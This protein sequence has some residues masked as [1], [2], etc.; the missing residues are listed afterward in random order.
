MGKQS[1]RQRQRGPN[2]AAEI[3]RCRDAGLP[4]FTGQAEDQEDEALARKLQSEWQE[5]NQNYRWKRLR[6]RIRRMSGPGGRTLCLKRDPELTRSRKCTVVELQEMLAV[7]ERHKVES[8]NGE[9]LMWNARYDV[10]TDWFDGQAMDEYLSAVVGFQ[11]AKMVA[12]GSWGACPVPLTI[13]KRKFLLMDVSTVERWPRIRPHWPRFR[14]RLCGLCPNH[15]HLV[16]P[17]YL[18]CSGCGVARYCSGACQAADWPE[19]Q[20]C[21]ATLRKSAEAHRDARKTAR[22][23]AEANRASAEANRASAEA[24]HLARETACVAASFVTK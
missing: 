22:A 16:E 18:V 13:V 7:Y 17:R 9:R 8:F 11:F 21:C 19:H 5:E 23:S 6:R 12:T 24:N 14:R 1:R 3:S 2:S 10:I 20:G 4:D 15:A